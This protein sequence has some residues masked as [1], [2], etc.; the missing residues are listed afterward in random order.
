MPAVPGT[1]APSVDAMSPGRSGHLANFRDVGGMPT[2]D[3]GTTRPGV[4]WRGD[5]PMPG[6]LTGPDDTG[7]LP[8]PPGSVVDLRNASESTGPHP[9]IARGSEVTVLP[10][11]Q[12]LAPDTQA[13]GKRGELTTGELY[14][15]LLEI[16]SAWLPPFLA[17]A[18]HGPGPLFVH[19][20]AG[21]DRTGVAV[22]LLLRSAGVDRATVA[23]DF[24]A[25][26]DH[27]RALRD[28]LVAQ[29]SL[30]EDVPAERVGVT[31][32]HIEPVLDVLDDD[33]RRPLLE[34]G[35]PAADLDAWRERLVDGT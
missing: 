29:G 34:A 7:G 14:L 3:G 10:L 9:L 21:K 8:W 19:C 13:R 12:S 18:A 17:V 1:T 32:E 5:A 35:V 11:V 4:L 26:N 27:R 16:G 23:A 31:P 28:R 6:D 15:L 33:P 20:A 2:V 22:A 30:G 24:A 25:T